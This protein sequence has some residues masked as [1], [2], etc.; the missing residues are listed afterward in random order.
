MERPGAGRAHLNALPAHQRT[1]GTISRLHILICRPNTRLGNTLLLTP[2][3]Q[4]IEQRLPGA[5]VDVLTAYPEADDVFCEYACVR[6]VH[7]LPLRG[8]RHPAA[9]VLTL[10][11]ARAQHYDLVLDP[12]P[13]SWSS[14]FAARLMRGAVKAGFTSTHKPAGA[15]VSVPITPA[16]PH[17][18]RFPVYLLRRAVLGQSVEQALA[19][20]PPLDIR[21]TAAERA[22]G[23]RVLRELTG[24]DS[25]PVIAL[26]AAA[27]G[28]KRFAPQWW[29][30]L[31][32]ALQEHARG[33]AL[34]EIRPPS[35]RAAF[36]S[37]PGF[38]SPRIRRVAAVIAA[39][40]LFACA[41][42]GL[43]HLGAASGGATLGL[44]KVTD[45]QV[46]APYGGSSGALQAADDAPTQT[47]REIA[48]RLSAS[49][50]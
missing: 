2:L 14:R 8:V 13:K 32:A 46:Y 6:R 29:S 9:H 41:D 42:S 20:V 27:T 18:A 47:A 16:P 31:I 23:A 1:S 26:A 28:A 15:Y 12:D 50:P 30:A 34:I 25:R 3:V 43:M 7:R 40:E 49:G 37:L 36:G 10:L 44:F 21:L 5:S 33:H 17:M 45:P 22:E 11:R 4:E 24:A 38:S 35:G 48:A 39:C 19:P